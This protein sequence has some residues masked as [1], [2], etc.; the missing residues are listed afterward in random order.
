MKK[1]DITLKHHKTGEIRRVKLVLKGHV[2]VPLVKLH[3]RVL[4]PGF[5][6]VKLTPLQ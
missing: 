6:V 5:M 3:A 4:N 1:F 2:T